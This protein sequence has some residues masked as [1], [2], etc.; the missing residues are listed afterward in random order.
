MVKA[1]VNKEGGITT[2]I[3]GSSDNINKNL[4]RAING[5]KTDGD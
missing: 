1:E 2:Q 4:I 5:E 3:K